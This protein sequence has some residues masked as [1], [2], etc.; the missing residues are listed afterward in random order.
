MIF[1]KK[2][3]S[4]K[5][6][7]YSLF[8]MILSILV[9]ITTTYFLDRRIENIKNL[10]EIKFYQQN[11][12]QKV[13]K[14]ML[15][16]V[17]LS[18]DIIVDQKETVS[19]DRE[20]LKESL[21]SSLLKDSNEIFIKEK[22]KQHNLTV[23]KIIEANEKLINLIN[24]KNFKDEDLAILDDIIDGEGELFL[25]ILSE[26]N[27]ILIKEFN[28]LND[29]Y[30]LFLKYN[31]YI[32]WAFLFL[33]LIQIIFNKKITNF[34]TNEIKNSF[35]KIERT[36]SQLNSVI[37]NLKIQS[38]NSSLLTKSL[39]S[40]TKETVLTLTDIEKLISDGVLKVDQTFNYAKNFKNISNEGMNTALMLKDSLN[41]L[42]SHSNLMKSN[43]QEKNK[44]LENILNIMHDIS[45]KSEIIQDISFQ[46]KILSFNASVEAS[47]AGEQ[48]RGFSIVAEEIGKL[49]SLTKTAANTIN[50][51]LKTSI[52][53]T[54]KIIK[55]NENSLIEFMNETNNKI[56]KSNDYCDKVEEDLKTI[57]NNSEEIQLM[58]S[59]LKDASKEQENGIKKINVTMNQI[60][61]DNNK[62]NILSQEIQESSSLLTTENETLNSLVSQLKTTIN[63][64]RK[65]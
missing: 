6:F 11:S 18:M 20:E 50:D 7:N 28:S 5:I 42:A 53:N 34:L 47:R 49:A 13:Q 39:F 21:K 62:S 44:E 9:F 23:Y 10:K 15:E 35:R 29:D 16:L 1:I 38:T 52:E 37:N 59:N 8:L 41:K 4:N 54:N 22:L 58:M 45:V 19:K 64:S 63:G 32:K 3:G 46:A 51:I 2:L 40:S 48:G 27:N 26:E 30:E 61:N 31:F 17:L 57:V 55:D 56:E 65:E 14:D 36:S 12:L 43:I 25:N 33:L 24:S 60:E